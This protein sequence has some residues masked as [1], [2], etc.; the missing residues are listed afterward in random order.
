MQQRYQTRVTDKGESV[1]VDT[2]TRK[3]ENPDLMLL[4]YHAN[5]PQDAAHVAERMNRDTIPVERIHPA[6][7]AAI[8]D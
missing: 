5:N 1:V 4:V 7:L 8:F 2:M 3:I 6:L